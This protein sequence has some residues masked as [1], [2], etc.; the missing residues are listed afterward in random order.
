MNNKVLF[1]E[2]L[3]CIPELGWDEKFGRRL[4]ET[5]NKA[6]VPQAHHLAKVLDFKK[7]P[8]AGG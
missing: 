2:V 7:E 4:E 5:E 6:Q 1:I 8:R 3:N